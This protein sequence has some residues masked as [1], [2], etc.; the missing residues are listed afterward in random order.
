M[1]G[2]RAWQHQ[3][4]ER[5]RPEATAV[6]SIPGGDEKGPPGQDSLYRE[7]GGMTART[8]SLGRRCQHHTARL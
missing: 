3:E 5:D 2:G 6:L 7:V 8:L 4:G 1:E